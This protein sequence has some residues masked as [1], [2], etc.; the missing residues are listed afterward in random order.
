M[1][2]GIDVSQHNG[3]L[4]WE[5]LKQCGV[6]FAIIRTSYGND[7][8]NQDDS[9]AEYNMA[10]CERLGIPYGVY[11]YSY[12]LTSSD[13]DSEVKHVLRVLNSH[14]PKLGVFFD[15]ED[16]DGYKRRN[17]IDVYKQGLMLTEFCIK[18][19][20]EI[21]KAGHKS[22]TYA[23]LD[24]FK[25][26]LDKSKLSKW[27]IWMAQ[28]GPSNPSMECNIWQ[29]SSTGSFD[30]ISGR[31]DMNYLYDDSSKPKKT[32]DELAQEVIDNK[33]GVNPE[34]KKR[35]IEE[36]YDYEAIQ[37]RV[38]EI[39]EHKNNGNTYVIKS[40]D[41]LSGIAKKFGTTVDELVNLNKIKDANI[42][43]AGS[44]IKIN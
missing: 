7:L 12:A 17:G 21:E 39:Y 32:I 33:W 37:A 23:N 22:G 29:Y 43:Y 36:G 8:H 41:T 1:K 40:G 3:T 13:V 9:K 24:Y 19:C 14:K 4:N 20:E 6:E 15:M 34:R 11:H 35:L 44:T 18:F 31:F 27:A 26:V 38:N 16:A 25:N 30:G 10:E 2:I 5:K 42:I 28:W